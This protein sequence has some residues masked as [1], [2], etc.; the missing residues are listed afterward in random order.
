MSYLSSNIFNIFPTLIVYLWHGVWMGCTR[1][2]TT[3]PIGTA[4]G[5][6]SPSIGLQDEGNLE[7]L[8]CLYPQRKGGV[9]PPLSAAFSSVFRFHLTGWTVHLKTK[10]PTAGSQRLR[11]AKKMLAPF[12]YGWDPRP[13]SVTTGTHAVNGSGAWKK[14]NSRQNAWIELS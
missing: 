14:Y 4:V 12:I 8:G 13:V 5:K 7:H 3:V 1:I 10:V 9:P 11:G 2:T 6:F